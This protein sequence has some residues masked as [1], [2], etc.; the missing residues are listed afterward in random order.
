MERSA[1]ESGAEDESTAESSDS[2]EHVSLYSVC[3]LY[4][5]ACIHVCVCVCVCVCVHKRER[6]REM[7]KNK[8]SACR[9]RNTESEM[10]GQ[11]SRHSMI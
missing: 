6:E 10:Q 9:V 1:E 7:D 8:K 2:D 3:T 5:F 4:M 11:M